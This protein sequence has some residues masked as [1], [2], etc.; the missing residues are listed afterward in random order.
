MA[1]SA[2]TGHGPGVVGDLVRRLQAV[3]RH[4]GALREDRA[5]D[6]VAG[7][8][9][10]VVD[11]VGAGRQLADAQVR[12][13]VVQPEEHGGVQVERA[14]EE[15][16]RVVH[17]LVDLLDARRARCRSLADLVSVGRLAGAEQAVAAR[18]LLDADELLLHARARGRPD[19]RHL[20]AEER[21]VQQREGARRSRVGREAARRRPRRA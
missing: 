1:A 19:A 14:A 8:E 9:G 13:G 2:R 18:V 15:V 4:A 7:G 11:V 16:E 10:R 12:P 6:A 17:R 21:E 3:E 5:E 20:G